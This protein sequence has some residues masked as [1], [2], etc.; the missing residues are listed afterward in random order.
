[1]PPFFISE[2]RERQEIHELGKRWKMKGGGVYQQQDN[3]H[4]D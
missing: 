3:K 1:M 4:E 2:N